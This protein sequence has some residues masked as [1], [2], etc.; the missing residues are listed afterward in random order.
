MGQDAMILVFWM[1]NFKPTFSLSFLTLIKR[2]FKFLYM[3]ESEH[4]SCSVV[5][6]SATSWTVARPPGFSVH[7]ILQARILEWVAIPFSRGS[8]Q[9][10]D[11][12]Q[13]SCTAGRFFTIWAT[14]EA[15]EWQV[16]KYSP[17]QLPPPIKDSNT[18]LSHTQHTQIYIKGR[19]KFDKRYVK[20]KVLFV[21]LEMEETDWEKKP[22][23]T[24]IENQK[25]T[26]NIIWGRHGNPFQ[27]SCLENPHRE[28]SLV[29]DSPWGH[30]EL[31]MTEQLCTVLK[32]KI[33][34]LGKG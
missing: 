4:V 10:R 28:R 31:D 7:G 20:G 21:N 23:L 22:V 27:Y 24:G 34:I 15:P 6:N 5:S 9:P 30:K 2:L 1:L 13:V 29:G 19:R 32:N 8:Y 11:Q 3:Y 17:I 18:S 25:K 12:T 14:R 26:D 16:L 33:N